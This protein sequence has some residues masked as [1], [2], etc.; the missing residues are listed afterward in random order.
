MKKIPQKTYQTFLKKM[1]SVNA[2]WALRAL[3]VVY[4][5]QTADEQMIQN[6][7]ELNG[8]GF[9][10]TDGQFGSSL[11]QGVEKYGRLS[12]KQM[13]FVFKMMP[14]Y[15]KQVLAVAD[16]AKLD[17]KIR[18]WENGTYTIPVE[19]QLPKKGNAPKK[20]E[21]STVTVD[22][23]Y[24]VLEYPFSKEINNDLFQNKTFAMFDNVTK[25]RRID[26]N[27]AKAYKSL[28]KI[29]R[30]LQGDFKKK[31]P[32]FTISQEVVS[33]DAK[34]SMPKANTS[35][36]VTFDHLKFTPF[37]YQ[38]EGIQFI[39]DNNGVAFIGDDMGLG[40]TMQA[41]GYTA[42]NNLKT[43]IVSPASLKYNWVQEIEKFSHKSAVVFDK[44]ALDLND[45]LNADYTVIN[46]DIVHKHADLL[47]S[48]G[49]GAIVC[50]ESHYLKNAKARRTQVT[51]EVIK[52]IDKKI[53]LS[54][55][56]IKS[57]PIEFFTQLNAL[58]PDMYDFSKFTRY[59]YKYTNPVKHSFGTDFTGS[60]NLQELYNTISEFYI[61]RNKVDVLTEL[62][63]KTRV[64]V[65]TK[66]DK[67]TIMLVDALMREAKKDKITKAAT[68]TAIGNVKQILSKAKLEQVEDL[69][70]TIMEN[71]EKVIIFSQYHDTIS[72]LKDVFG[73]TAVTLT[74]KNS[75]QQKDEAVKAF[76]NDPNTKVIIGNTNAMGVGFTLTASSKVIFVDLPWTPGELLQ[77]EDR[78]LRIG[79]KNAVTCYNFVAKGTYEDC[80]LDL[81]INKAKVL[82][83]ALDGKAS[84]TDGLSTV[85]DDLIAILRKSL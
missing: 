19:S 11:A 71:D 10:G 72:K 83:Q 56:A 7:S 81:L 45:M 60:S 85:E 33:L 64:V 31:Y 39:Q 4:S 30:Y 74:G 27:N 32:Q 43:L 26:I 5:N 48:V 65:P 63:T 67:K 22:G 25:T 29:L 80:I 69:A 59:A 47:K 37:D 18:A 41:I 53:L 84:D 36:K 57:R 51:L 42:F 58:R 13:K 28:T 20:V 73:D 79:Q 77:A 23:D 8:E 6:T 35:K 82:E 21:P 76:Q 14:K 75:T 78:S 68:L 40:K 12:D 54:G 49:F 16:V 24:I 46:Y 44:K 52:S 38:K 66:L 3:E 15:W 55:T 34:T 2:T 50:D 1:L 62:P 17:S 9:T 70:N 61:R